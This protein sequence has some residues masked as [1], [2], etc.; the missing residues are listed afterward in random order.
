MNKKTTKDDQIQY[1]E[2]QN[3]LMEAEVRVLKAKLEVMEKYSHHIPIITGAIER[4]MDCVAHVL[5]DLKRE[6]KR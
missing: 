6:V 1:L 4:V 5:T 3:K 2:W